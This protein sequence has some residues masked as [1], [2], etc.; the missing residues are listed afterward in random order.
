MNRL[1]PYA[2]FS[3]LG[4]ALGLTC[5]AVLVG[6]AYGGFPGPGWIMVGWFVI[7]ASVIFYG[8]FRHYLGLE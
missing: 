7:V 6:D 3:A 2:A 5:V 8:W 1:E 4:V